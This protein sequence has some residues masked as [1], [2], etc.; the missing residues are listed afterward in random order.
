M[1]IVSYYKNLLASP[2]RVLLLLVPPPAASTLLF[3]NNFIAIWAAWPT[4]SCF[5]SPGA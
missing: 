5:E 3:K 4:T 1:Y 2:I